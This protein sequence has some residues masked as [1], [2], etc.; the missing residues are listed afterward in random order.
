MV[1]YTHLQMNPQTMKAIVNPDN[2]C[3]TYEYHMTV[4]DNYIAL[5]FTQ[6]LWA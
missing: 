4:C 2:H 6:F 5:K 3:S 1:T